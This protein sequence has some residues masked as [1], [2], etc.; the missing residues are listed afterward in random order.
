VIVYF[1]SKSDHDLFCGHVCSSYLLEIKK[2][3]GVLYES[4]LVSRRGAAFCVYLLKASTPAKKH[5]RWFAMAKALEMQTPRLMKRESKKTW[6]TV[7]KK[8]LMQPLL[9]RCFRLMLEL[10]TLIEG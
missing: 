4:K 5:W 2:S 7:E 3:L 10:M 9:D 8:V 6:I 1:L